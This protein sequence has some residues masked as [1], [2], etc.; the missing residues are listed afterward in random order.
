MIL[1]FTEHLS[2]LFL[3]DLTFSLWLLCG[4]RPPS[5]SMDLNKTAHQWRKKR[6]RSQT[7]NYPGAPESD[8]LS[9]AQGEKFPLTHYPPAYGENI[10]EMVNLRKHC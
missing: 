3:G 5:I 8:R 6:G 10:K 2:W 4:F 1:R 9:A 7:S